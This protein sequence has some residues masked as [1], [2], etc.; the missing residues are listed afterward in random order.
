MR[1]VAVKV[2]QLSGGWSDAKKQGYVRHAMREY[3]IH[4]ALRHAHVVALT[5]IFELDAS[6]FA[7]VLELCTGGDLDSHLKQQQA[8]SCQL[9]QLQ[10]TAL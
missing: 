4:K 7:T 9:M 6:A 1:E 10:G 2:H 3:R 5:D 8:R